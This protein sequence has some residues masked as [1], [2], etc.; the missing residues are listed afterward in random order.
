M[1]NLIHLQV[2]NPKDDETPI[3]SATQIFAS[4]LPYPY[5]PLWKR[6]FLKPNTYSFEIYLIAQTIYFYIT[7]PEQ[8]ETLVNSLITSSF[9]TSQLKRTS[10]PMELIFKSKKLAYGQLA[11]NSYTYLPTKT[12]LDFKDVDPLSSLTGFLSKQP[13]HLKM[14]VQIVITPAYFPWADEAVSIA[15]KMIYD[16]NSGRYTQNPQKLLIMKKA[17]FQGGKVAIRLLVGSTYENIDP[18][19][20]LTQLAGTFGSFS[21]GEGNQYIFKK[22]YFFKDSSLKRIKNRKISYFEAQ[23]Q[24]LNAQELATIWHPPGIL[25]SGIKNIAW[26]KT[27]LGEPPENLPIA[28]NIKEEEKNKLISLLKLSSKTKTRFLV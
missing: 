22:I 16:T 17:S 2:R 21:L 27:L 18:Y 15:H 5:I 24:I 28:T 10:D 11:L 12:Y 26:G 7:A 4:L 3:E 25:L 19:P 23:H 14:A 8:T 6:W 20:F 1:S 9:P 13:P